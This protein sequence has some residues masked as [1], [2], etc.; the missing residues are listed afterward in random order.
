MDRRRSHF[1]KRAIDPV[2]DLEVFL[3]RLEVDVGRLFLDG[4]V[5]DQVHIADDWRG[6]RLRIVVRV[7]VADVQLAEDVLHRLALAAVTFVD[8]LFDQ[9]VRSNHQIDLAA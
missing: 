9:I 7:D 4:L 8:L 1:I 3:E 6:V 5:H 2:A